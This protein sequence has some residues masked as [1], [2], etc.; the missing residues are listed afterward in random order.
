MTTIASLVRG[1]GW[2][3]SRKTPGA[4]SATPSS[5]RAA[6]RARSTKNDHTTGCGA[7]RPARPTPRVDG[8]RV[9]GVVLVADANRVADRFIVPER[10]W[11]VAYP[12]AARFARPFRLSS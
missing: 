7:A 11:Q 2:G 5:S 1:A 10:L 4:I 3:V 6:T 9:R 8:R 12:T